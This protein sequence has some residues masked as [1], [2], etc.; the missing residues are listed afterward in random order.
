MA[1]IPQHLTSVSLGSRSGPPPGRRLLALTLVV[2]LVLGSVFPG[3]ALAGE[4]DSEG[5]GTAPPVEVPVDPG[6]DPG[7]EEEVLEEARRRRRR[8]NGHGRSRSRSRS[9]GATARRRPRRGHRTAYR[10][11][12]A[13]IRARPATC[14][15][16]PRTC[17]P[18]GIRAASRACRERSDRRAEAEAGQ[19]QHGDRGRGFGRSCA[20]CR[21]CPARSPAP[22]ASAC[23]CDLARVGPQ[24]H[25]EGRLCRPA[26][27]LPVAYRRRPAA[28]RRRHS[29]DRRGGRAAVAA[30][31]RPD[32]H[33]R[34][35]PDLRRDRAAAALKPPPRSA[36]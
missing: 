36:P 22:R 16:G 31:R 8:R 34:P 11:G 5:E 15:L 25:R 21:T 26:R 28:G 30:E 27:R 4:S 29:G 33:R 2:M 20:T 1:N 3:F 12:A 7:G 18:A 17:T 23:R 13:R 19:T 10:S 35:E 32:R 24:P 14:D 9:P 6:F